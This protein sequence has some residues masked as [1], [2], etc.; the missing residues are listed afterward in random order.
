MAYKRK[1]SDTSSGWLQALVFNA[2]LV[3]LPLV[4]AR[5]T[6]EAFTPRAVGETAT[7]EAIFET[8]RNVDTAF[9]ALPP[10]SAERRSFWADLIDRELRERD[11]SAARGF[12]LAAPQMLDPADVRAVKA[13]ADA[14]TSGTEDQRIARAAMLFLPNDVRAR[15]DRA[16]RPPRVDVASEEDAPQAEP[17]SVAPA[18]LRVQQRFSVLGDFGDLS[19]LSRRWIDGDRVDPFVLKLTGLGLIGPDHVDTE[20]DIALAASVL[21]AA[22]RAGRLQP[23]YVRYL[24]QRIGSVISE[25]TLGP[26]LNEAVGE[27][28]PRGIAARRTEE[29]F[30]ASFSPEALPRLEKDLKQIN[31]IAEATSPANAIDLIEYARSSDDILRARLVTEASGDRASALA[32]QI[33]ADVLGLAEAGQAWTRDLVLKVMLLS[34]LAMAGLWTAASVCFGAFRPDHSHGLTVI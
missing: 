13:A 15:Y 22:H 34:A 6:V 16:L 27:F 21:K 9:A 26:A 2:L 25:D 32:S 7:P 29:A 11:M 3:L 10:G 30:A 33:G 28:A 1:N 23:G 24:D 4:A 18:R 12:L 19:D 8:R 31:A 17:A 20:T 14:E 5:T